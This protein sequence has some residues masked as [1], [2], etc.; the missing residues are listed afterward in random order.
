MSNNKSAYEIQAAL[1]HC[2]GTEQYYRH[3]LVRS[4]LYTDGVQTFCEMAGAYWFLDIVAT[5]VLPL[6]R[7]EE[8]IAVTL[9]VTK[10]AALIKADN[11]SRRKLWSRIIDFTDCPEGIW[12]F[13]LQNNV[14]M[15]PSEY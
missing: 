10:T 15:V 9:I 13:Y 11:G 5:E 2:T 1:R 14:F 4:F 3:G 6:Q 8:F 7:R 12:K